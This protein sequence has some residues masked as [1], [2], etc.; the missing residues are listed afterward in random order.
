MLLITNTRGNVFH[1]S[2]L[3]DPLSSACPSL[4]YFRFRR[5]LRKHQSA[6]DQIRNKPAWVSLLSSRTTTWRL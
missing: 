5:L 2:C 3:G 6:L 1:L 4:H